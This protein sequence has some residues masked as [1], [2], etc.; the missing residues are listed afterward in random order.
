M[1]LILTTV[2]VLAPVAGA[3]NHQHFEVG[4]PRPVGAS[5]P[6]AGTSLGLVGGNPAGK[7]FHLLPRPVGQRPLQR[8]GGYYMLDENPRTLFPADS[9]SLTAA[10]DGQ[11]DL[12]SPAH[13]H[14]GAWI[15]CE[16]VSVSGP[17]GGHFGFW[18]QDHSR[19][20][21]A[22]SQ[23]FPTHQ[24]TGSFSFVI[25]EGIDD[26]EDDPSGHVHNRSWTADRAGTYLV[27]LRFVDLS[28]SGPGGGSWHVPSPVYQLH[29]EAGPDFMPTIVR[30]GN[31]NTLIWA[32]RMGIYQPQQTGVVFTILR[33]ASPD[34]AEWQ[35]IGM[36]TG[37]TA[38]TVHFTDSSPLPRR[39]FY[40]LAYAWTPKL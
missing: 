10:S 19:Y 39:A 25:S 22:P 29:F 15:W 40:R 5:Q 37:T 35:P 21:D 36:V 17:P 7:T 11:Y 3:Q 16:I 20:F 30:D 12:K 8:C 6:S 4:V 31:A 13:A 28:T 9:F 26:P 38:G 23:S 27:G 33:A 2:I 1:K 18:D 34:A 24:P 14:T 32:S